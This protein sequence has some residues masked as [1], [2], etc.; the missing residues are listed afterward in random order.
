VTTTTALEA[1]LAAIRPA[2]EAARLATMRALD[3]KTKPRGSLGAIEDLVC[4]IAA[5]RGATPASPPSPAIIVV[6]ADHGVAAEGVSAYPSEVT[7]QMLETF[8]SGGAA[9]S[10]LAR[11]AGA[12]LIVLDA[13]VA[14]AA[15][16]PGVRRLDL[17]RGTANLA[18]GPAMTRG[19]AVSAIEAGIDLAAELVRDGI[20]V[21]AVGEMGIANTTSA[22]AMCAALLGVRAEAVCGRGTGVDD[23]GLARKIRAV[24]RGLAVND[25]DATDPIGVL[26]AVGGLEIAVASGIMLGCSAG[27]VPAI[28]DGAV[29]GAAALVAARLAPACVDAM[30][31]A[32]RS[33]EP[34]HTLVLLD[35]GLSPLLDLGLRLGEASGAALALPLVR[36]AL[37][38]LHEMATFEDAGVTDAGA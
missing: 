22:A 30:I 14:T 36:A 23:E 12:R 28:L 25:I 35:L 11:Q 8:A 13:G 17:P 15:P 1:T 24:R 18:A 37:A 27:R 4:R 2:D 38:L 19:Q 5:I 6:A 29:V 3:A 26:A 21:V 33:P 20:D 10:V 16:I 7:A 31:A 34:A 9:I 32:T